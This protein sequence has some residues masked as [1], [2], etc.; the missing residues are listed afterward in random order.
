MAQGAV[1]ALDAAG[2]THG[3]NGKVKIIGFDFNRFALRN[4]QAGYWDCDIQCSPRQA[5]EISKWIKARQES[6]HGEGLPEGNHRRYRHEHRQ[7][8]RRK[9]HQRRSRQGR[10]HEVTFF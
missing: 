1:Q 8:H 2:I 3:K 4:I 5:A 7:T 10:D 9:G 6:S